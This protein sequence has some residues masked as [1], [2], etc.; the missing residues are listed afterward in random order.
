VVSA[1][2][3][4][5]AIIANWTFETSQPNTTGPINPEV[6]SGAASAFGVGGLNSPIGNSSAH[7]SYSGNAWAVG[8][9]CNFK[10]ARSVFL[11]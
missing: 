9:Y 11:A 8:D 4:L 10:S 7:Y 1:W 6:G 2:T 3:T 5:A